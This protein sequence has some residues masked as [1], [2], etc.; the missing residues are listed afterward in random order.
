MDAATSLAKQGFSFD[1]IV[2]IL[3]NPDLPKPVPG[4]RIPGFQMGGPVTSTGPAL[5]HAGEFVIPQQ[6]ALV[7]T[8]QTGLP[9]TMNF[10]LQ[11][12]DYTAARRAAA[13]IMQQL[14]SVRLFGTA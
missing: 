9:P 2:Y 12:G 5:L 3:E 14:K 10:Y 4:P 8:G 1:Q 13:I 6:G 11:A 7:N